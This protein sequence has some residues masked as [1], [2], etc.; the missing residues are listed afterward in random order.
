MSSAPRQPREP[1]E[2]ADPADAGDPPAPVAVAKPAATVVLARDAADGMEIVLVERHGKLRFMGGMHVFPGGSLHAGD[3]SLELRALTRRGECVRDWPAGHQETSGLGL[4]IA[5]L[6]ETFEEVGLWLGASP[7]AEEARAVRT[8]LLAGEDFA[9]L[10]RDAGWL[11]EPSRLHPMSR[12]ITP[13]SEP[14]RFDTRFYAALA[15]HDQAASHD[16]GETVSVIWRSPQAAI[17]DARAGRIRLSPPTYLTLHELEE[18]RSAD[19]LLAYCASHTPP[20]IEPIL[21]VKDG[22]RT[23]LYPGDPEHPVRERMLGG[24]TRVVF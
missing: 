2:T 8:R 1:G 4:A 3:T 22:V 17:A 16:A 20:L 15:P 5:A 19:A 7:P 12:W 10:L 13:R 9:Q 14:I 21:Q 11:L 24:P 23:V 6:R 18:I